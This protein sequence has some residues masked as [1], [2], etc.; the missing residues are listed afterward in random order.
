M[1]FQSRVWQDK[2]IVREWFKNGA[3]VSTLHLLDDHT[4]RLNT[5]DTVLLLWVR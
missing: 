3:S 2:D 4:H 5:N 1:I